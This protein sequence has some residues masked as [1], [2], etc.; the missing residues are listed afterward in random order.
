MNSRKLVPILIALAGLA[1]YANSLSVPF[2]FDDLLSIRDNPRIRS[3][4]PPWAPLI[5]TSRPVVQFSLA[6]NYAVGRLDVAGYHAVNL[7]IHIL[8]ALTLFGIVKRTLAAWGHAADNSTSL[9]GAVALVWMVHPLQTE[10]VT[11]VIQRAESLMGL[12]YLLTIYCFIRGWH[13]AAVAACALGMASK[14]VM[15]TAPVVV[16]LY[17]KVFMAGSFAQAL[18]KRWALYAGLAATWA[19]LPVLL[20]SGAREWRTDAGFG[21]RDVTAG[22][23]LRTQPGVILNYLALSL[24]PD[25]LVLDYGWPVARTA[26]E[27]ALP[28][29]AIAGLIAATIWAVRRKPAIGFVGAFFFLALAP[30]SSFIPIRD[31]A[32]EHRMYLPLAAVVALVVIGGR[33]LMQSYWGNAARPVQIGLVVAVVALFGIG[34][35][36]RNEVYRSELSIWRDTAKK[37]PQNSRARYNHG[38][39]LQLAGRPDEAITEYSAAV[40]LR[41]DYA[42]AHYA[43]GTALA[44]LGKHQEAV[45]SY[46]EALRFRPGYLLAHFNMGIALVKL[47]QADEA[48]RQYNEVLRLDPQHTD[49]RIN[50]GSIYYSQGKF[51]EAVAQFTEALRIDAH[52]SEAHFNLGL[53]LHEQGKLGEAATHYT[54]ALRLRPG[55]AEAH[56]NLGAVLFVQGK[57][58]EAAGHFAEALRLKPEYPEARRNLQ[59]AQ[60]TLQQTGA[61]P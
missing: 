52:S 37:R 13:V 51:A 56:N 29:L 11:Y 39:A 18:R 14:P 40:R 38:I 27:I 28:A 35:V 33:A 22:D 55:H 57:I 23:Y 7:A 58:K 5:D 19:L 25:P 34:T 44:K 46:R 10:S 20:A 16:L 43:M 32:F 21:F 30:S 59:S 45:R 9:A 47:G 2:L 12:F 60:Q 8:A 17:D 6:L 26:G 36:R 31:I 54:E 48:I 53:A 50:L 49:A 15:A 42:D 61:P 41:P 1:V 4:S 3:L 24:W